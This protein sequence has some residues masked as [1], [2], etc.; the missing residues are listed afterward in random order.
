MSAIV[1]QAVACV[2]EQLFWMRFVPPRRAPRIRILPHGLADLPAIGLVETVAKAN[3]ANR[4]VRR[5]T[6]GRAVGHILDAA[7]DSRVNDDI[8]YASIG[9]NESQAAMIAARGRL[10][11]ITRVDFGGDYE[12]GPQL[13]SGG[14]SAG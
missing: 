6:A 1:P 8:H 2:G 11:E 3:K 4:I 10:D 12:N 5:V 7:D 14:S 9:L 13:V